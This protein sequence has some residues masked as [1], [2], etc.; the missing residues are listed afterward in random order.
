VRRSA[1]DEKGRDALMASSGLPLNEVL[2]GAALE[3]ERMP[4]AAQVVER[5]RRLVLTGQLPPGTRLIQE[6]V[7][8]ELRVSRTPLREAIRVLVHE[9][10]LTTEGGNATVRVAEFSDEDGRELYEVRE[11]VDGLAARLCATRGLSEE[12]LDHL[13]TLADQLVTSVEAEPLDARMFVAVHA[14]FHLD[15]LEASGNKRL[16]RL[17]SIVGMSAQMLFPRYAT[18]TER[19]KVSAAEHAHILDAIRSGDGERAEQ[20]AR[21]HIRGA[22]ESWFPVTET[23]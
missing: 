21:A 18:R 6:E 8:S 15:I 20:L 13:A 12:R 5:L 14:Q 23:S 9:G 17:D 16:Q 4:L 11:V 2:Q 22:S 19:M 10:L 1:Y 7:A 3:Q